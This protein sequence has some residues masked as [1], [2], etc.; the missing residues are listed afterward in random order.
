[1]DPGDRAMYWGE[2]L[3]DLKETVDVNLETI[4]EFEQHLRN[5][6]EPSVGADAPSA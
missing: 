3:E 5:E 1:M 2:F 6:F 4:D